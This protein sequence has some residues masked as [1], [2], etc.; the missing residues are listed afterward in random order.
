MIAPNIYISSKLRCSFCWDPPL[1]NNVAN[2]LANHG[3][4]SFLGVGKIA[5]CGRIV[6]VVKVCGLDRLFVGRNW[7]FLYSGASFGFFGYFVYIMYT[8]FHSITLT[9]TKIFMELDI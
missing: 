4:R 3:A 8:S 7:W 9:L 2:A 5:Y 1:G 6:I